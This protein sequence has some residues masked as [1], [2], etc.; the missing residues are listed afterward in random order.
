MKKEQLKEMIKQVILENRNKTVL[1]ET[2]TISEDKEPKYDKL[3]G[4]LQ[5]DSDIRTVGIMSG[6]NPMA[7]APDPRLNVLLD[8]KLKIRL[9]ELGLKSMAIGGIFSGLTEKS[10]VILNV[11]EDQMDQLNREFKQWGFVFG[12]RIAIKEGENFM[13]FTMYEVDYDNDMGYRKDPDS[14]ETGFVI[15]DRDLKGVDDN[16]SYDPTSGKKF[17]LELYEEGE[18]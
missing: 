6:Q 7:T 5:G 2:P 4:I 3:M 16:V 1:L 9:N 12:R 14:K 13:A 11:S 10:R 17:G 15:K 8:R 18:E